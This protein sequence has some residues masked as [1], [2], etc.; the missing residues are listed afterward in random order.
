MIRCL[1]RSTANSLGRTIGRILAY[2]LIGVLLIFLSSFLNT[3]NVH[4]SV[5]DFDNFKLPSYA[6]FYNCSSKDHCVDDVGNT[7]QTND[8]INDQIVA[9]FVSPSLTTTPSGAGALID[10]YVDEGFIEGN[11][12]TI[13]ILMRGGSTSLTADTINDFKAGTGKYAH[14]YYYS[15][16]VEVQSVDN[17]HVC[18]NSVC[19]NFPVTVLT[20][21]FEAQLTGNYVGV[22]FTTTSRYSGNFTFSG[23]TYADHGA[24]AP[25]IH[26]INDVIQSNLTNVKNEISQEIFDATGHIDT[27]INFATTAINSAINV[28]MNSIN[29]NI[30][31][32]KENVDNSLNSE[33]SDVESGKCGVICKLKGI[34]NGII[35]L[36]ENIWNLIKAGFEWIVN[37]IN[38]LLEGIKDLFTPKDCTKSKNLLD[39]NKIEKGTG[40]T[41]HGEV[42]ITDTGFIL[43][44]D[45]QSG[46]SIGA[47]YHFGK[48]SQFTADFY[49]ISFKD[50]KSLN[51]RFSCGSFSQ[52]VNSGGSTVNFKR[53]CDPNSDATIY[54]N[55]DINSKDYEFSEVMMSEGREAIPYEPY[56]DVC[57]SSGNLFDWFK[58]LF[59]KI[60]GFFKDDDISDSSNVAGDFFNGFEDKDYGLSDVIILPLSFVKKIGSSSCSTLSLPLPFVNTN[61]ELPCMS[62]VYNT[63]FSAILTIYQLVTTGFIGYWVSINLFKMAKGFKDPTTDEVE[64]LD[65]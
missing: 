22:L 37:A 39:L 15:K 18:Y 35:H 62:N 40:Y 8:V 47:V 20:Y 50:S 45:G 33:D 51:A 25:S 19:S 53:D 57:E 29:D 63:H 49:R 21:T 60:L 55:R 2:I 17:L 61:V 46:G 24:N 54:F 5:V 32:M 12:Y 44:W 26:Q 13:T 42:E 1:F 16:D 10:F 36:P 65:L 14:A 3:A 58:G 4:A 30:D 38:N 41:S 23:Y 48:A 59:D 43:H 27:S 11:Y 9:E 34:W 7:T 64:V 56:G 6:K 28:M 52:N 31:E